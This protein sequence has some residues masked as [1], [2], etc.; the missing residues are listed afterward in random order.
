MGVAPAPVGFCRS[1]PKVT[2][3]PRIEKEVSHSDLRV[4]LSRGEPSRAMLTVALWTAVKHGGCRR[5][6]GSTAVVPIYRR[7]IVGVLCS[8]V[9]LA[10]VVRTPYEV[11]IPLRKRRNLRYTLR[12]LLLV[13]PG[14]AWQGWRR[15]VVPGRRQQRWLIQGPGP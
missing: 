8:L 2:T 1:G 6:W 15:S 13:C 5:P 7:N 9:L 11:N 10:S 12:L 4:D 3:S 14:N